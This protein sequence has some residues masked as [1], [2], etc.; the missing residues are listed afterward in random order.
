MEISSTSWLHVA[1]LFYSLGLWHALATVIQRKQQMFKTVVLSFFL[2]AAAHLVS[3]VD[4]TITVGKI[5]VSTLHQ[6]ASLI[7]FL[8][9]CFFLL[10][11]WRYKYESLAVFVF[12]TV[13]LLTLVGSL[14]APVTAW[15]GHSLMSWWL[16]L[17]VVLFLL[18]FAAL[19]LTSCSGMMYIIQENELKSKRPRTFYYRLPPLGT[20]D[21]ISYYSLAV[22]FALCT[23]AL[24]TGS[25]WA[26][27]EWGA[28]WVVDP[29]IALSF[30]TWLI[31]L[32]MIFG[33][34]A[35]GWRGRKAAYLSILG[36]CSAALTWITNSGVHSFMQR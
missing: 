26:F 14:A 10:F 21:D 6:M 7:G 36:F 22:G 12:P 33:R 28:N 27:V 1:L 9:T 16:P 15:K 24:I 13:F 20:L 32:G 23:L 19:F 5:P 3:I 34:L 17:H 2:G 4:Q 29:T 35:I 8:I 31:Y 25:V 30:L 11:Y 18:G